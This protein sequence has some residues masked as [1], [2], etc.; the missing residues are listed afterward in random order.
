[1]SALV[2]DH[3][4]RVQPSGVVTGEVVAE[5]A[6]R[7]RA[8]AIAVPDAASDLAGYIVVQHAELGGHM[9]QPQTLLSGGVDAAKKG[10]P[11]VLAPMPCKVVKLNVAKGQAVKVGHVLLVLESMKMEM[12]VACETDGVVSEVSCAAGQVVK[13]GAPLLTVQPPAKL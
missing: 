2:I 8:Y 1:M 13:E 6:G 10:G 11:V 3:S 7:R 12:Q 4:R 5:I 9:L